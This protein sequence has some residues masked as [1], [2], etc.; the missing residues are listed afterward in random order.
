[1]EAATEALSRALDD[2]P[3]MDCGKA[4]SGCMPPLGT[5]GCPGLRLEYSFGYRAFEVL[6]QHSLAIVK[7][8]AIAQL[9]TGVYSGHVEV[10]VKRE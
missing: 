3:K 2:K 5:C 9:S 7:V 6:K 8:C 1:M 10:G 4:R